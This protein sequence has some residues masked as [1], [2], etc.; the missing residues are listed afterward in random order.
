MAGRAHQP[1]WSSQPAM[2]MRKG[3]CLGAAV[4]LALAAVA[5]QGQVTPVIT[6]NSGPAVNV[7]IFPAAATPYSAVVSLAAASTAIGARPRPAKPAVQ[8]PIRVGCPLSIGKEA[9]ADVSALV[10]PCL[11]P[12]SL[13]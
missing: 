9:R 12:P 3:R 8:K 10:T 6:A 2:E 11:V 4:L 13:P 7:T 1:S 5:A